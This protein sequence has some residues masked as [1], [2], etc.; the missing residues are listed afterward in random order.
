MIV[1][2]GWQDGETALIKASSNG[3]LEVVRALMERNADINAP[4]KVQWVVG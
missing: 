2:S 4:T 3:H 1:K